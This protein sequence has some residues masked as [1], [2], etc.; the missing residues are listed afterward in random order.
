MS[1]CDQSLLLT[2]KWGAEIV[3]QIFWSTLITLVLLPIYFVHSWVSIYRTFTRFTRQC[4]AGLGVSTPL[5]QRLSG[6]TPS[7]IYLQFQS[8]FSSCKYVPSTICGFSDSGH[9]ISWVAETLVSVCMLQFQSK[10]G[11]HC[12]SIS[13]TKHLG[14]FES[15]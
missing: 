9:A 2:F 11:E 12:I 1:C 7:S 4:F 3:S 15:Q 8:S 6:R 13:P 5:L 14:N 10:E